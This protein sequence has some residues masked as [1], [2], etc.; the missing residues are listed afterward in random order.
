MFKDPIS[1]AYTLYSR[2]NW[3]ILALD[4]VVVGNTEAEIGNKESAMKLSRASYGVSIAVVAQHNFVGALFN[5]F[6]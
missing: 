2:I 6:V 4:V 3:V 1:Y 5:G